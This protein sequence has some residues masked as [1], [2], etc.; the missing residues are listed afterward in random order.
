MG[1]WR[2][3]IAFMTDRIRQSIGGVCIAAVCAILGFVAD[4]Y[5][6]GVGAL[7]YFLALLIGVVSLLNIGLD[8]MQKRD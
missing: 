3:S 8:L 4:A 6:D 5:V 2:R 1:V 7:L